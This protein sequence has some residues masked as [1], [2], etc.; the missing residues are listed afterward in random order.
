MHIHMKLHFYNL[1][2][3]FNLTLDHTYTHTKREHTSLLAEIGT[4]H[5]PSCERQSFE[6]RGDQARQTP[7]VA[8]R[9]GSSTF[10]YP[11]AFVA[12]PS[13]T[14]STPP[15]QLSPFHLFF[16]SLSLHFCPASHTHPRWRHFPADYPAAFT[17][18]HSLSSSSHL[19]EAFVDRRNGSQI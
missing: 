8:G 4:I 5:K 3:G 14:H 13:S 16:I 6:V 7:P 11:L 9:V 18:A 2:Y 15:Q 17:L 19:T 12:L 1:I 10:S